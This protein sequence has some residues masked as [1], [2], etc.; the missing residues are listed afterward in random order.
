MHAD[1][2]MYLSKAVCICIY[3]YSYFF[4]CFCSELEFYSGSVV[5]IHARSCF[6]KSLPLFKV[7][8][9]DAINIINMFAIW[10]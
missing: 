2:C 6:N 9:V 8:T 3:L 1:V 7:C 5:L 4:F 10:F